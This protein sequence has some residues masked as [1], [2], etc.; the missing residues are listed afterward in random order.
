L[1]KE[2]SCDRITADNGKEFAEHECIANELKTDIC[3]AYPYSSWG[4]DTNENTYGQ[5]VIRNGENVILVDPGK[6][7]ELARTIIDLVKDEERRKD[8]GEKDHATVETYFSWDNVCRR[9]L[10]VYG[11]TTLSFKKRNSR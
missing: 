2:V 8:I 3:F 7:R 11:K 6:P 1:D 4:R 5:G 10:E 9:T